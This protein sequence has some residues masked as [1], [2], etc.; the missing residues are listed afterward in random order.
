VGA[1]IPKL[2]SITGSQF[3]DVLNGN[4]RMAILAKTPLHG[5]GFT[6]A[7]RYFVY[8]FVRIRFRG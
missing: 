2:K 1:S 4:C 5:D 6:A 3:E 8:H 7:F